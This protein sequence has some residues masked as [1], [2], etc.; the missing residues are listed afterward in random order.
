MY[1]LMN[2]CL[3]ALDLSWMDIGLERV[4]LCPGTLVFPVETLPSSLLWSSTYGDAIQGGGRYWRYST[5]VE[6][7]DV[8]L[9]VE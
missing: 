4:A 1:L 8:V 6:C 2:G 9:L 3:A 7:K 5:R